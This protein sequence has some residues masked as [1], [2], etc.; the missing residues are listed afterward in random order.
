MTDP[1]DRLRKLINRPDSWNFAG[2]ERFYAGIDLGT[3]KTIAII[4]DETGQ[5]RAARMQR[6]EVARS[7]LI[8]D[9]VGALNT[10]RDLMEEMRK[11]CPV[12]IEQGATS[13][14]PQTEYANL[15]TTTHIL[16][17]V[18][19]EVLNVLD[20]PTAANQVLKIEN[21]AIVDVGGGTT[22]IAVIKDGEVVYTNDEATGGVHLSLVLA[23]NHKISY[24]EAEEIKIDRRR[25][26]EVLSIVRP[27]IE[28]IASIAATYLK[29]F[30]NLDKVCLV[31]GTCEL[32][33]F[34]DIVA[35]NIGLETFRPAI[36]QLI[37]P[38]GI[39]L[40][41]LNDGADRQRDE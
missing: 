10:T 40:S 26:Q 15:K 39:A 31:G 1:I 33:G 23:G 17:G 35:E 20:E 34:S 25:N 5:P 12:E 14:P 32:D 7:G 4:I 41:C 24:E 18:G 3:Y 22:G 19:L 16:E 8:V 21:G 28:K 37:T 6:T 38:F 2:A 13:F 36:P 29:E 27:V 9:Y 11:H 30:D